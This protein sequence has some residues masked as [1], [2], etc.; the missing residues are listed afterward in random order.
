M[1]CE[2]VDFQSFKKKTA[3]KKRFGQRRQRKVISRLHLM[4]ALIDCYQAEMSKIAAQPKIQKLCSEK[5]V[6]AERQITE[7]VQRLY[8]LRDA[9]KTSILEKGAKDLEEASHLIRYWAHRETIE[10]L[11]RVLA[12]DYLGFKRIARLLTPYI[13]D[14]EEGFYKGL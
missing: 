5:G 6:N 13:E 11:D 1:A 4:S 2:I 12:S 3:E 10:T 14:R 9:L 8:D 7:D